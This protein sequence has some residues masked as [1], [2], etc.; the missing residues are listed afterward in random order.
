MRTVYINDIDSFIVISD[1]HLVHPND[2]LTQSFLL[3]LR[4]LKNVQALF[5]LGDIFDFIAGS[6][7]FFQTF[8]QSVFDEFKRLKNSGVRVYFMEGNHDFGFEHFKSSRFLECFTEC[9]DFCVQLNHKKWGQILLRHGD[10]IVCPK[11]YL[12]FRALVKS[13][14]LQKLLFSLIPGFILYKIFSK[15]AKISRKNDP[16]RKL[17][18]DF[19]KNCIHSFIVNYKHELNVLLIG[20]IHVE[21]DFVFSNINNNLSSLR[22]ISGRAW[23][24]SKN[25][26][27]VDSMTIERKLID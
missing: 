1:V 27:F 8:W 18:F 3:T 13:F 11:N 22:F 14:I 23:Y 15:Y 24:E 5:L 6:H 12:F 21:Y 2:Q 17:S 10:D 7:L 9:G 4:N 19:L 20:H 26:L 25:Y 16:Y